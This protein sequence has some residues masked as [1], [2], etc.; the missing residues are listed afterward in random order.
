MPPSVC[1]GYM[2]VLA[3]TVAPGPPLWETTPDT[4]TEILHESANFFY[5]N[6][7]IH[8]AD[9]PTPLPPFPEHPVSEAVFNFVGAWGL[10]FLPVMLQDEQTARARV[11]AVSVQWVALMLLTNVFFI[12]YLA[13]RAAAPAA[14]VRAAGLPAAER[15]A[16]SLSRAG[17]APFSAALRAAAAASPAT[18]AASAGRRG[19]VRDR[20]FGATGL[21]VGLVSIS[22]A[23]AA[24]PEYGGL[25]DRWQFFLEQTFVSSRV[26]FMF[27]VDAALYSLWQFVLLGAAGAALRYRAVPFFG[28]AAWL[29][30]G[31][32]GTE[33][34]K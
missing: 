23:L 19:G 29:L 22:W 6:P 8:A 17:A 27:L 28:L 2:F 26:A 25:V 24:R 1:A 20:A 7:A 16:A 31:S 33:E 32:P 13:Q 30:A 3:G 15:T 10:M 21:V 5:V 14:E 34:E 9:L 12:P 11:P 18:P 4:L